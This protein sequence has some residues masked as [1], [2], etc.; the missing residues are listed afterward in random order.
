[1]EVMAPRVLTR[2][3]LRPEDIRPRFEG[4]EVIG[5]FNPAAVSCGDRVVLLIRV[6]ERP[7][8]VRAGF[9]S[10]RRHGVIFCPENKDVVLF[11]E[12]VGSEYVALHRPNP[13]A[14]FSASEIW[15]AR[16][17]DLLH[18]GS[19]RRL[20]GSEAAWVTGKIGGGTPPVRTDRRWLSLFHGHIRPQRPGEVGQYAAAVL[21]QDLDDPDRVVGISPWPVMLAEHDFERSGFL[22]DVVFPS[23]L[24]R[25][26]DQLD[27]YYGAADTS[28]GV[29]RFSLAD[30]LAAVEPI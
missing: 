15:L 30:I 23:G 25:R 1:M 16:S 5:V 18:W 2:R 11:P 7:R 22:T 17:S 14:H 19:H 24:V 8:E 10:F 9:R 21:L 28:T 12:Q 29:A 4:F 13:D 27:V 20:L 6:A 3:L 26:G